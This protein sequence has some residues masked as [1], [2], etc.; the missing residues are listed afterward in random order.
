[1]YAEGRVNMKVTID[2]DGCIECGVCE[3]TCSDVFVLEA[4]EKA[5]IVADYRKSTPG[6]GEI[7]DSLTDCASN[8]ASNC[9]VQVITV[10]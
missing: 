5:A 7:P 4:G 2:R 9:P 1:V 8:A 10:G 3:N 6:E